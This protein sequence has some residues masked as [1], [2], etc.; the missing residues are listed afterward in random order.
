MY[1]RPQRE[2]S[3]RM[4]EYLRP[5]TERTPTYGI[6]PS[7]PFDFLFRLFKANISRTD[8]TLVGHDG[9]SILILSN[10]EP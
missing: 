6:L 4:R 7:S 2:S 1:I 8:T 5:V 9:D 3:P 10:H